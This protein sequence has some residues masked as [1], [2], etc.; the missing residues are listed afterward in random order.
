[1]ETVSVKNLSFSY[2]KRRGILQDIS[3]TA[4]T[5]EALV[6]AGLSGCG[7]TTLL[8]ILCGVIPHVLKG[9]L[10]GEIKLCGNTPA[11]LAEAAKLAGLV[12]QD[13]DTQIVCTTVEDE[14]AFGLENFCIP[15]EIIRE[16]V[17]G[18]ASRMGLGGML[19]RDPATLS[20][21][22]K[23]LLCIGSVLLLDP[24]VIL[25][26]EPMSG[27]DEKSR[28]M[29]RGA[30]TDLCGSGKTVIVVEHDLVLTDYADRILYLEG[31]SLKN[32]NS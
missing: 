3:F 16:K 21:G 26:D 13:S 28:E 32:D 17:D 24:A 22:E 19:L 14:L 30:I 10:Y 20:G 9:E 31:G 15:P 12:F 29:V 23:K 2:R 6:I 25:L 18:M 7:K 8:H 1:M 5:G 4:E 27:L 11:S